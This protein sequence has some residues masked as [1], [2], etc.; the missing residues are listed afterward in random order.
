MSCSRA[1]CGVNTA[2]AASLGCSIRRSAKA[3][4]IRAAVE[5]GLIELS[6]ASSTEA[7]ADGPYQLISIAQARE[8]GIRPI[9][10]RNAVQPSFGSAGAVRKA[11]TGM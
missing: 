3:A 6:R 2:I 1:A 5:E 4:V 7:P 9:G 10:H 11:I 8:R